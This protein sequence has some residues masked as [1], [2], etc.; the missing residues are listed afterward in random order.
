MTKQVTQKTVKLNL[1]DYIRN[2]DFYESQVQEF[3]PILNQFLYTTET[4]LFYGASGSAK[5]FFTYGLCAA[6]A[7]EDVS[8]FLGQAIGTGKV[9]YVDGEMHAN[10]INARA[11]NF[12]T[13][14]LDNLHYLAMTEVVDKG[15]TVDLSKDNQRADVVE[16]VK[17]GGYDLVV[18]DSVRTLFDLPDENAS[19]SWNPVNDLAMRLRST[20][21]SVIVIHHSNKSSYTDGEVIWSGSSNAVTVFDRTCGIQVEAE[22]IWS[23]SSGHKVGRSGDGYAEWVDCSAFSFDEL[24]STFRLVDLEDDRT[25]L[26]VDY[27]DSYEPSTVRKYVTRDAVRAIYKLLGVS[28][29]SRSSSVKQCW[30]FI[31]DLLEDVEQLPFEW[32]SKEF[33]R[34]LREGH[35]NDDF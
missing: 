29:K 4:M 23:L 19:Q 11:D 35:A 30:E 33:Q 1:S 8:E 27:F 12:G 17:V 25:K 13:K 16:V 7:D 21:A 15:V 2:T 32:D 24:A 6:F 14:R 34:F 26:L 31:K 9:L 22:G 3:K 18:I 5:S 20:G 28:A 10:T